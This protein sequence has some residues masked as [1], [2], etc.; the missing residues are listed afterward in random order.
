MGTLPQ[1]IAQIDTERIG[2]RGLR[3]FFNIDHVTKLLCERHRIASKDQHFARLQ[4]ESIRHCLQQALEYREAA[5]AGSFTRPTLTYYSIM[6]FALC[7]ILFKRDGNSRLSKLREKHSHHGLDFSVQVPKG[8]RSAIALDAL[9][10]EARKNG[11]FAVW[12]ESSSYPGLFGKVIQITGTGRVIGLQELAIA[13][14]I[15]RSLNKLTLL[16]LALG[17]PAIYT[18]CNDLGI[19]SRL[20]RASVE[21]T[22]D[23][24]KKTF[25]VRT[26]IHP[27]PQRVLEDVWKHIL[28]SPRCVDLV[29]PLEFASGG[30]FNIV[31]PDDSD[32]VEI[33]FPLG[34]SI[35]ENLT[36]FST[37]DFM[38]NEFGIYY[39]ASYIAGMFAR[40][41]PEHWAKAMD[42][43]DQTFQVIDSM[44]T[45]ALNRT[46]L[47]LLGELR[48]RH[49]IYES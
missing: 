7:E 23:H 42:S 36:L 19:A 47:L 46:P 45:A 34:F 32:Y 43:G 16:H 31:A 28:F 48:N 11:T 35:R 33:S 38:L 39:L 21:I 6:S 9:S 22:Q 37:E 41:Y 14:D 49:Y 26:I 10:V 24:N 13:E 1:K 27:T 8:F 40:Y 17:C 29:R 30:G 4:A 18:D 3:S 44:M 12:H 20:A 15:T 2:L 5:L 25:L